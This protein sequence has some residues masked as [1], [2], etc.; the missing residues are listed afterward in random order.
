M[1]KVTVTKIPQL[2]TLVVKQSEGRDFFIAS[3]NTFVISI[4][5][6]SFLLKFLVE[7]GYLSHKVLEGVLEEYNS[8]KGVMLG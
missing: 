6:F 4:S 1:T 3:S 5:S 7:N 2:N 8:S